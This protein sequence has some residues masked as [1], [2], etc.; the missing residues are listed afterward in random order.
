MRA[1]RR[2]RARA[3]VRGAGLRGVVDAQDA[4]EVVPAHLPAES[5]LCCCAP[6]LC[7]ARPCRCTRTHL[8]RCA[9]PRCFAQLRCCAAVW[10]GTL[11]HRGRSTAHACARPAGVRRDIPRARVGTASSVAGHVRDCRRAAKEGEENPLSLSML[12]KG[13]IR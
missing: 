2:A 6:L 1:C 13:Q 12:L 10:R 3:R 8:F 5:E 4:G 7:A 11:S 9:R